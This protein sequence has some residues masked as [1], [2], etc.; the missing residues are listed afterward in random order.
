VL[1][2]VGTCERW[3]G[4]ATVVM[5]EATRQRG[6]HESLARRYDSSALPGTTDHEAQRLHGVM[7][8][9]WARDNRVHG[10]LEVAMGEETNRTRRGDSA[11]H[12]AVM[13]QLALHL[14]RRETAVP[15]GIAAQQKRAGWDHSYLL[16]I[17]AQT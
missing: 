1:A 5:G 15:A 7:R 2:G 14:L 16:K 6:D 3:P 12:L 4:W 13:R 8:T 10:V 9:H 17:V 11:P